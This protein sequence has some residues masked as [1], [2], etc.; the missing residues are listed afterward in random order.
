MRSAGIVLG[1]GAVPL[2]EAVGEA[3]LGVGFLRR[4]RQHD[5]VDGLAGC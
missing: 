1:G 3:A 4:G 2:V 5:V